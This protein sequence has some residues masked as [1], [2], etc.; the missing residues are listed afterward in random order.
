M[1]SYL[2]P[3]LLEARAARHYRVS[4][5]KTAALA[6]GGHFLGWKGMYFALSNLPRMVHYF[7][8]PNTH[9]VHWLHGKTTWKR[10][11]VW[12]WQAENCLGKVGKENVQHTA[13]VESA[14]DTSCKTADKIVRHG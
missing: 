4:R 6:L 8:N 7:F 2:F 3:V 5:V 14:E 12:R 10:K 11:S 9:D 13:A 1:Q